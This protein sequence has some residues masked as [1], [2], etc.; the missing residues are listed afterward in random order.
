MKGRN[1]SL[2]YYTVVEQHLFTPETGAYCTYGIRVTDTDGAE[3]NFISDI[4][5]DAV[6][7][8]TLAEQCNV[9]ELNHLHLRDVVLDAISQ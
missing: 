8:A 6:F 3:V 7:V 2:S 4:S 5:T 9:L 1:R